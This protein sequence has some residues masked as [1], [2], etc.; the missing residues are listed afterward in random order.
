MSDGKKKLSKKNYFWTRKK[1]IA[2]IICLIIFASAVI[3]GYPLIVEYINNLNDHSNGD[4]VLTI[5]DLENPDV[6]LTPNTSNNSVENLTEELKAKIDKQIVDKEN[7][8]NTVKA[9]VGVLYNTT[10]AERQD[11]LTIFLEDFL[12]NRED[13]LWFQNE[14]NMPDQAQVNYWKSE[15]YSYLIHYYQVLTENEFT[16]ADGELIDTT[17]NQ[18]KY[19]DLYL[20]L[21]NDPASNSITQENDSDI[22]SGYIYKEANYFLE[23]KNRL[24]SGGGGE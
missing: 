4:K 22:T 17:Q 5:K 15:L 6:E 3:F 8:I 13:A 11:Q 1:V 7:P 19:I 16:D 21:A 2:I 10:N 9:L 18:L 12:I 24:N 23:L 14:Y 20:A